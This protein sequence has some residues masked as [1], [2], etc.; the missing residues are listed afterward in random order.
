MNWKITVTA[1]F[2]LFSCLSRAEN[3][4]HYSYKSYLE[5]EMRRNSVPVAHTCYA[6]EVDR[7]LRTLKHLK[8][9]IGVKPDGSCE[10]VTVLSPFPEKVKKCME[11]DLCKKNFKKL[12][13]QISREESTFELS[14]FFHQKH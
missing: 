2:L 7:F 12:P 9:T 1:L 4:H 10:K 6:K 11:R 13:K 3:A 8:V 14:I 5:N